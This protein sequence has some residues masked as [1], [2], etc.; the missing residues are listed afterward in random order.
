MKF[1]MRAGSFVAVVL[2]GLVMSDLAGAGETRGKEPERLRLGTECTGTLI[3]VTLKNEGAAPVRVPHG[4]DENPLDV[5]HVAVVDSDFKLV[6]LTDEGSAAIEAAMIWSHSRKLLPGSERTV[7][8]DLN[9]YFS[10]AHGGPFALRLAVRWLR[11]EGP[12]TPRGTQEA[13]SNILLSDTLVIDS[14]QGRAAD[15]GK[16]RSGREKFVKTAAP[17]CDKFI[18][19]L[20]YERVVGLLSSAKL[21][22]EEDWPQEYRAFAASRSLA[23]LQK[24]LGF[25][26][27]T[28]YAVDLAKLAGDLKEASGKEEHSTQKAK[29]RKDEP[30]AEEKKRSED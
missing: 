10:T 26:R 8:F 28:A 21:A 18:R 4:G 22:F 5:F 16:T 27:N 9:K 15:K 12:R 29:K 11:K 1:L 23:S 14:G 13:S 24:E 30:E 20:A 7:T 6:K 17:I 3:T 19:R 2:W 25:F